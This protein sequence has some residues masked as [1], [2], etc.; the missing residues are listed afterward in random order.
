VVKKTDQ[1]PSL[2][3]SLADITKVIEKMEHGELTLEQSLAEFERGITLIRQCQKML[4][5]AEQKV[6]ILIQKNNQ[7]TLTAY[8]DESTE[9]NNDDDQ[10]D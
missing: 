4:A 6:Q 2:E 5:E 1:Q 3:T 8:G 7:D 9:G 10:A